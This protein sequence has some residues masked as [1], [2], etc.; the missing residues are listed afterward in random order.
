MNLVVIAVKPVLKC[1]T[2]GW[3]KWLKCVGPTGTS[4]FPILP[5]GEENALKPPKSKWLI[6]AKIKSRYGCFQ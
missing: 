6:P 2:L 1:I 3:P 5:I 4:V